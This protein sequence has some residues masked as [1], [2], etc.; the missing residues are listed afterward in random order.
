MKFSRV[1]ASILPVLQLFWGAA[2]DLSVHAHLRQATNRE[3]QSTTEYKAISNLKKTAVVDSVNYAVQQLLVSQTNRYPFAK[4]VSNSDVPYK[5]KAVQGMQKIDANSG[6]SVYLLMIQM[7]DPQKNCVGAFQVTVRNKSG[8]L[9]IDQWGKNL[10]CDESQGIVTY[11]INTI[12][13][14]V[15]PTGYTRMTDLTDAGVTSVAQYAVKNLLLTR[16]PS[17][18]FL[19]NYDDSKAS[20]YKFNMV[21]AFQQNAPSGGTNY[22]VV[23]Q[24]FDLK[25]VCRGSFTAT[26]LRNNKSGLVTVSNYGGEGTCDPNT[27]S[28]QTSTVT[29]TWIPITNFKNPKV[30]DVAQ[31]AL[32]RL[33]ALNTGNP[34][35]FTNKLKDLGSKASYEI[36]GGSKVGD[37]QGMMYRLNLKVT[38]GSGGCVGKL[39]VA[40]FDRTDR[41]FIY[42]WGPEDKCSLPAN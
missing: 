29:G 2:A 6:D 8:T 1:V 32:D 13:G 20:K 28:A 21:E 14:G 22:R 12:G 18:S 42:Q 40:V 27:T 31:F 36:Y 7:Q 3:L 9:S 41:L 38:N 5:W 34:Y 39:Q 17:Y 25:G 15:I 35:T 4:A 23:L 33:R 10:S 24:F 19:S 11:T 16:K 37:S 26:A 30:Q